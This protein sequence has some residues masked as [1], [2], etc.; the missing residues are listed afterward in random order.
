MIKTEKYTYNEETGQLN[1]ETGH[2]LFVALNELFGFKIDL[3][4]SYAAKQYQVVSDGLKFEGDF[5]DF[6]NMLNASN[7]VKV[8]VA[9]SNRNAAP[10]HVL[11]IKKIE[12][13]KT[14]DKRQ[15]K[16]STS[17]KDKA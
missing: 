6:L 12:E 17:R 2:N 11:Y 13:V 10:R 3:L 7:K 15:V 16:K 9:K 1:T 5:E 8:S 4:Q 14:E